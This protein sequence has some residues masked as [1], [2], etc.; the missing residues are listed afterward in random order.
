MGLFVLSAIARHIL[1]IFLYL[2]SPFKAYWQHVN[3]VQACI[4]LHVTH[5]LFLGRIKGRLK[6]C[7]LAY[8]TPLACLSWKAGKRRW[9]WAS[10]GIGATQYGIA[11]L[12]QILNILFQKVFLPHCLSFCSAVSTCWVYFLNCFSNY[13]CYH[14]FIYVLLSWCI[15]SW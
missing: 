11:Q 6:I 9:T 3:E 4:P 12:A 10:S 1:E 2:V 15:N 14:V 7:P 8:T 5:C 13:F